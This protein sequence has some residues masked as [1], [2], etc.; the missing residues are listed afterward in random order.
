MSFTF[1]SF[2]QWKQIFKVLKKKEKI[3]F[4]CFFVLALGSLG[5][6]TTDFYYPEKATSE[7]ASKS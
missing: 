3:T 2:S 1:P 5:F 7:Q 4:L 6:L